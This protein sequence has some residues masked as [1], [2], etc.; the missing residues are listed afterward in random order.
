MISSLKQNDD[1]EKTKWYIFFFLLI[2]KVCCQCRFLWLYLAIYPYWSSLLASPLNNNQCLQTAD[3][4]NF[5]LVDQHL[6]PS[7]GVHWKMSL[8]SL[9]LLYQ[10]CPACHTHISG[11]VYEIRGKWQYMCCFV[12]CCFL[13]LF[14]MQHSYAV[15]IKF[16]QCMFC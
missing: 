5:W 13:D 14:K 7:V 4:Y 2:I 16:F 1:N 3:K 11:M 8:M 15:S 9:S 6:C 10:Q 12:G